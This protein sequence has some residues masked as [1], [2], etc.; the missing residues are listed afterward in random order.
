M[1]V[2]KEKYNEAFNKVLDASYKIS[3]K[4]QYSDADRELV[5]YTLRQVTGNLK[6]TKGQNMELMLYVIENVIDKIEEK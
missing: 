1:K 2:T 4:P 6:R 3:Q 5:L